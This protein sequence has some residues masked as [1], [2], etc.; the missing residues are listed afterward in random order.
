MET[1]FESN[2]NRSTSAQRWQNSSASYAE[3]ASDELKN[4]IA[5]IEDVVQKAANVSDE[6]VARVRE[7][8]LAAVS[9]TSSK[10]AVTTENV[11][12]RAKQASKYADEYVHESP[13]RA[14]CIAGV[15]GMVTGVMAGRR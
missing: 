1:S 9:S 7:K 13:W 8:V 11:K 15:L 2:A 6:D 14:I 4:F 3:T 12:E 5:D 10:L